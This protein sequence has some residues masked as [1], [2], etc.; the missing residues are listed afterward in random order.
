MDEARA[1]LL[2]KVWRAI[3]RRKQ[4]LTAAI[5]EHRVSI[6][7]PG[8]NVHKIVKEINECELKLALLDELVA[9]GAS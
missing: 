9:E 6:R 2:E 1:D 3:I 8:S 4:A 5:V 7:Q